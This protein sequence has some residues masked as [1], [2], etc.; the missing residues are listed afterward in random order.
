MSEKVRFGPANP[1]PLTQLK[2][3][4]VWEGKYDDYGNRQQQWQDISRERWR[5]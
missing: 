2:T 5:R 3:E 4:L 1:H